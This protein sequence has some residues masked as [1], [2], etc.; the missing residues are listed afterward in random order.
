MCS[1]ANFRRIRIRFR[2]RSFQA[3]C[4]EFESRLPLSAPNP[5]CM[6]AFPRAS[7]RDEGT[8]SELVAGVTEGIAL[9]VREDFSRRHP[10][11]MAWGASIVEVAVSNDEAPPPIPLGF[12]G[13]SE[14]L[15]H[16]GQ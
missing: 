5:R 8:G 13:C 6:A 2:V 3:G 7:R 15:K 4:R 1:N 9:G 12:P 11:H 14:V 10:E 16:L